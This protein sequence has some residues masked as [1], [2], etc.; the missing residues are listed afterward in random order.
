MKKDKQS[1]T[2]FCLK[3]NDI[4]DSDIIDAL[5]GVKNKTD[6]IRQLIRDDLT[7]GVND[8]AVERHW[9]IFSTCG[10][11]IQLFGGE[12]DHRA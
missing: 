5:W 2:K 6:Y 10:G 11:N 12:H 4:N 9:D 7:I 1:Y 3:L 8:G